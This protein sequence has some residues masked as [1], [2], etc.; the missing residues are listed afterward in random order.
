MN[1]VNGSTLTLGL[2]G[3]LAVGAAL[4]RRGSAASSETE[5][6]LAAVAEEQARLDAEVKARQAKLDAARRKPITDD[7]DW[8]EWLDHLAGRV[9]E[10][11][12]DAARYRAM[13]R[14]RE[15]VEAVRGLDR[16]VALRSAEVLVAA[17]RAAGGPSQLRVWT[18]PGV[19]VRVYFPGEIGY[20]SVGSDGSV[21]ETSR[22]KLHFAESGLYP[23]WK[24]AVREGRRAYLQQLGA[25]LEAAGEARAARMD[26]VRKGSAA[27]TESGMGRYRFVTNCIGSTYE[28]ISALKQTAT[29]VSRATF[30]RALGPE[31]WKWIQKELGYDR[32]FRISGDWHVGYDK[33]TYRGVPAY[34]LTHGGIEWI[35]TLDGEQGKSLAR[36]RGSRAMD[37]GW[38]DFPDEPEPDLSPL[39]RAW[40]AFASARGAL[41]EHIDASDLFRAWPEG[42]DHRVGIVQR[43]V[44]GADPGWFVYATGARTEAE[45]TRVGKRVQAALVAPRSLR[46]DQIRLHALPL[47]VG[48][49]GGTV[50]VGAARGT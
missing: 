26:A 2:V 44:R 17:I 5:A 11:K 3:A 25:R 24:K 32:D 13:Q 14:E 21:S 6:R 41:P 34:W 4:G 43:H 18:K 16:D 36:R 12:A 38:D 15:A 39:D 45:A 50:E 28:D 33:G 46:A 20:L 27:R 31:E 37:W 10:A 1:P 35:F 9:E 8:E 42:V 40:Q 30:A 7:P 23:A 49:S 29:G 22:G 19:G 48:W 47:T